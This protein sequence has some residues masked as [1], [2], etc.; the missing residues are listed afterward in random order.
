MSNIPRS[1]ARS[2]CVSPYNRAISPV[3]WQDNLSRKHSEVEV[4]LQRPILARGR[5]ALAALLAGTL[6]LVSGC[7]SSG[8][9]RPGSAQYT[10]FVDAFYVGLSAFQVG[11]DARA[12]KRFQQA[13][14]LAP[15]EPAAWADWGI[16]ALR[17]RDFTAAK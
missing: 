9:P 15:G 6:A 8:L 7:H 3:E 2:G 1:D 17:E 5:H 12:D 16:L 13:T 10:Q 11:N 14:Q 4:T